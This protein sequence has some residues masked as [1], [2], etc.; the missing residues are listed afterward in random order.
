MPYS[1]AC[2]TPLSNFE[3]GLDYR[4]VSDPAI[5][6]SFPIVNCKF[7]ASLVAW[8]TTPW[9]LPAN[10]ALCV[11]PDLTYVYL[12]SPTGEVYVLAEAR[13]AMIPGATSKGKGGK[14]A[15]LSDNWK[16]LKNIAGKDLEDLKYK[17][18]FS[19]Y[20]RE[21]VNAFR[22]CT[23]GYVTD[24]SG[25]GVVH[26]APAYGED[27]FRVCLD[28]NIILKDGTL[29]DPVDANG[30]FTFPL[31]IPILGMHVK[32]ADK[33]IIN[34]VKNENR[35]I[36]SS[37]IKHSY[38]YCWRSRTPLI[39]KAV[40]SYFV[41]VEDLKEKLLI[42]NSQTR[43]VPSYVQEKRFHNW[44]ENAHDWAISR[45]RYWGTPIPVWSSPEGDEVFVIG[46][47]SE[48]EE[49]TGQKVSDIHRHFID[50]LEIPS[51]RGANYPPL[52]RVEEVF[53]CWFESGS[54]PY[55]QQ[56]YPF[57][58]EGTFDQKFPAN[59]IAEGLDQTRGWFY[60]L[61]VLS[62]ALF[63]KPAFQNLVC[64][65][66][67]LA[68]D[69]KKMS[70]S[71]KNYPDPNEIFNKYGADALRLYLINSPVVRAEP[72]RFQESGVFS[73]LKDVFLP[74]Y[75]AYR[76]LVQNVRRIEGEQQS[77]FNPL[78]RVNDENILD[79]WISS[80]SN[81]LINFVQR[82]ME[83]YRLYT[84]VPRLIN[85]IDQLTNVYVRF[86][87]DRLKGKLGFE[88]SLISLTT[89]FNVL[90]TL[91]KVM[92]P[93]TPFFVEN[94]YQNLRRCLPNSEESVHFCPFPEVDEGKEFPRVEKSVANM[95][96]VIETGRLIRERSNRPIKYPIS[97]MIVIH[98]DKE[99]LEDLSGPL[100]EYVTSELNI[101]CLETCSDPLKYSVLK[102][103]PVFS[104]LGKR[105][106]K[107]MGA[108]SDHIKEMS[109]ENISKFQQNGQ[110]HFLGHEV[111]ISEVAIR[112]EF[113]DKN[114]LG[115][116]VDAAMGDSGIMVIL[117]LH[118]D[119]SLLY[120]GLAREIVSKIQKMRKTGGL[121]SSNEVLIQYQ[122]I[123][124]DEN[125]SKFLDIFVRE[126]DY[127][128]KTL[129]YVPQAANKSL[130]EAIVITSETV[131]LSTGDQVL[132]MLNKPTV[133]VKEE[134]LLQTCAGNIELCEALSTL[135]KSINFSF[136]SRRIQ[137]GDNTFWV[138][139]DG[140]RLKLL[141]GYDFTV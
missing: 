34:L 80:A 121:Q 73:V 68:V 23:D 69:G 100:L 10:L 46:S 5:T 27:D 57:E 59:F 133:I 63:D 134:S 45:N 130:S 74:W 105:L 60:T 111:T 117:E 118:V 29:P 41:R 35:L 44:L 141:N 89:L 136:F 58:N 77:L 90:L 124:S 49:F 83:A 61:M 31:P 18:L 25:T 67:V 110:I 39:Y 7:G 2:N 103:E 102:A 30:C 17:P 37:S 126:K 52:R 97:K 139:I 20:E 55:A 127:F 50:H 84:V 104:L 24:I 13:I 86:N 12:Q 125:T 109:S 4:D 101:R 95:Q 64:N 16:V 56:H 93:F 71:L 137:E 106:G 96:S 75:N 36:E 82:E 94:M 53:D 62:T 42:N 26:Q 91:C 66:L 48:L 92:A 38:P 19:Y 129:G 140:N 113:K 22:V 1:T 115:E 85:Y 51:K 33:E 76:F 43:W 81:G 28:N 132:F 88:E 116:D 122:I 14:K 107:S 135:L 128:E 32:A 8:T 79:Q 3:A 131:N 15:V 138:D 114:E 78:M 112:Y 9:T 40:A 119:D 11:N 87:R 99:F 54:M 72:L 65:G 47:I 123:R 120:A 108:I 98:S 70:K 21:M 6:I